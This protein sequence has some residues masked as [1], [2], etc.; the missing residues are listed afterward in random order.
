MY[1][2]RHDIDTQPDNV[3]SICERKQQKITPTRT[4]RSEVKLQ[5]TARQKMSSCTESGENVTTWN[6]DR[7]LMAAT[8]NIDVPYPAKPGSRRCTWPALAVF[9][10]ALRVKRAQSRPPSE[11]NYYCFLLRSLAGSSRW[12]RAASATKR[13][14]ELKIARSLSLSLSLSWERDDPLTRKSPLVGVEVRIHRAVESLTSAISYDA[15]P[16]AG[17]MKAKMRLARDKGG[18]FL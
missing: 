7:L 15:R 10:D 3:T 2:T 11:W 1:H 17:W 16:C 14:G 9:R 18:N 8:S 12:P 5:Y 6:H 13:T 4:W